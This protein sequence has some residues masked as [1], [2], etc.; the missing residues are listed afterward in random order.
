MLVQAHPQLPVLGVLQPE[1]EGTGALER[2]P[3]DDHVRAPTRDYVVASDQS[4]DGLGRRRRVP[5]EDPRVLVDLHRA[6]VDPRATGRVG[7]LE[8]PSEL[9]GRPDVVVVDEGDPPTVCLRR[10]VVPARSNAAR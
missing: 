2:V 9:L 7:G 10:A 4:S 8:L 1:V 3:P 5:T 6:G